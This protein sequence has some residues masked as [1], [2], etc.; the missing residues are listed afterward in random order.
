MKQLNVIETDVNEA[1]E[2]LN[3]SIGTIGERFI[4]Y[5]HNK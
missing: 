3:E 5:I 4:V 1:Y 2:S